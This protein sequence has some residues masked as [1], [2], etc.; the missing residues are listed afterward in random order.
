M[1]TQID[2]EP[3]IDLVKAVAIMLV[4]L[5]HAEGRLAAH[6]LTSAGWAAVTTA[7]GTLRMP[8]FFLVSGLFARKSL[9][10]AL[11]VFC[12]RKVWR[13]LWIYLLW[14]VGYVA[15]LALIGVVD[16]DGAFSDEAKGWVTG[17]L[18][19]SSELWYMVALPVFFLGARA[20][21]RMSVPVQLVGAA[22]L[23]FLFGAGLMQFGMWGPD[24]MADYF[25]YFLIGCYFGKVIRSLTVRVRWPS[26]VICGVAWVSLCI[27]LSGTAGENLG[28]A[29]LPLLAVPFTLMLAAVLARRAW[30]GPLVWLGRNTL[31]VYVMHFAPVSLIVLAVRRAQ[32]IA[33]GSYL[34]M[35]SPVLVSAASLGVI[36]CVHPLMARWAPW[37][38]ALPAPHRTPATDPRTAPAPLQ[39]PVRAPGW[40][41]RTVP[42][43]V[44]LTSQWLA[45]P[46]ARS[47]FPG[48][49]PR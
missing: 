47:R 30:T 18:T 4:V 44:Q 6:G 39:R 12:T 23:S 32:L 42:L 28:N 33:P 21:R 15:M 49:S 36:L 20:M 14:S 40:E 9:T 3:W 26:A 13:F 19:A 8:T 35:A 22:S 17:S 34:A 24:H 16:H 43:P 27:T 45:Q 38:L 1:P 5:M 11:P 37:S 2:R 41:D 10:L 46:P 31:P 29:L 25:V 48:W 7:L